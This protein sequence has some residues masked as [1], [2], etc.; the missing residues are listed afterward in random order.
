VGGA[1]RE[2]AL[3]EQVAISIDIA[4]DAILHFKH[5]RLVVFVLRHGL[6]AVARQEGQALLL[7]ELRSVHD[8]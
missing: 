2:A 4:S 3:V 6:D 5:V 7:R 1:Q 8:K